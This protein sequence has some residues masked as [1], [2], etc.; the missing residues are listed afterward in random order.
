MAKAFTPE[1]WKEFNDL[2]K[3][4]QRALI[5]ELDASQSMF[6]RTGTVNEWVDAVNSE[7]EVLKRYEA[8]RKEYAWG[9][10]PT[11]K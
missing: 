3:E 5:A 7:K 6:D 10:D 1:T 9:E 2:F 4:L 8:M 11:L